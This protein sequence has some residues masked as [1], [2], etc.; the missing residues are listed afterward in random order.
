VGPGPRVRGWAIVSCDGDEEARYRERRFAF[1]ARAAVCLF[2]TRSS[3]HN[4]YDLWTQAP[5]S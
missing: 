4:P 5:M 3:A 2:R 1:W